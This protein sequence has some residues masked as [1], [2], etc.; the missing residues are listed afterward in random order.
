MTYPIFTALW[1]KHLRK[2]VIR[3]ADRPRGFGGNLMI[4]KMNLAHTPL[5]LWGLGFLTVPP[6][7]CCLDI[8][9]GG[10]HNMH[11]L[12]ARSGDGRVCGI[13]ISKLSVRRSALHNL[14]A[15]LNGRASVRRGSAGNLP[16]R[17]GYFDV[18]TAFETVY[19][20][21]DLPAAFREVQRV[22]RRGG[23]FLICNEDM[24]YEDE[25]H[26]HD[27]IAEILPIRFYT[28]E[29]L[30]NMLLQAGFDRVEVHPHKNGSWVS[31][32]AHK[33]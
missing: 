24:A 10:G 18:V 12:L 30:K 20:W 23:T 27:A 5:S 11:R 17:D 25:P 2:R 6:G 31:L 26:A 29:A 33:F 15:L 4:V 28:N 13:D 8:G 19:Y 16:W 21:P 7:A 32:I 14:P 3:T 9:C 22:L 1:E